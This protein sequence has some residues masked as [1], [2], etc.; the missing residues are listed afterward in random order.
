M[1]LPEAAQIEDFLYRELQKHWP[2]GLVNVRE[3]V[4]LIPD[5]YKF[6]PEDPYFLAQKQGKVPQHYSLYFDSE[7]VCDFDSTYLPEAVL[8]LFWRGILPLYNEHKIYFDKRFYKAEDDLVTEEKKVK[9]HKRKEQ[10]R[11]LDI[12]TE[13]KEVIT[14]LDQQAEKKGKG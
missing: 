13:A 4:R 1:Y 7:F 12:P 5:L 10:I 2:K 11:K 3:R 6:K 9:K 14:A 8:L